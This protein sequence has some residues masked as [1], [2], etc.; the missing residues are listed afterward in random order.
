VSWLGRVLR[1]FCSLFCSLEIRDS[2]CV[3]WPYGPGTVLIGVGGVDD[4]PAGGRSIFFLCHHRL[5]LVLG[6]I[7]SFNSINCMY[8]IRLSG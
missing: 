6:L 7:M 3:H 1:G 8:Y 2:L 4:I 5:A